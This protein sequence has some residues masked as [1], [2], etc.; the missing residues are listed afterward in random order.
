MTA[1]HEG[2]NE[3]KGKW[4]KSKAIVEKLIAG[5]TLTADEQ[6]TLEEIQVKRAQRETKKAILE[7]IMEMKVQVN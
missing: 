7:P 1:E 4:S 6:V 3:G 5:E 2:K